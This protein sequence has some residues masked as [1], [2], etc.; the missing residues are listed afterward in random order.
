ML[1]TGLGI[2]SITMMAV[3][4]L[5]AAMTAD[6]AVTVFTGHL[7]RVNA[8]AFSPDGTQVLTGSGDKTAKLWDAFTG[9]EIRTFTGH[10]SEV[11]SVAFSPDGT[12]VLTGSTDYSAK[13]WNAASGAFVRTYSGHTDTVRS[14]AFS[15]DG[16]QVLTGSNDLSAKL[17]NMSTGALVHTFTGHLSGVYAVAFSPDGTQVLTGSGDQTAQIWNASTGVKGMA[18]GKHGAAVNSVAF[19]PDGTKVLT[20]LS[21]NTAILWNASTGALIRTFTGHTGAVNSAVFSPDGSK[22]FT[23]SLDYTAKLWNSATG[24]LLQTLAGHTY[25]VR[26]AAFSPDGAAVLTG[27]WDNTARLETLPVPKGTILIDNNHT[28]TNNTAATLGL[29]WSGGWGTGVARMRFSDDGAHWTAWEPLLATRAYT[30]P[31]GDGYKTVRVQFLDQL[32]NTSAV[33]SDYIRLDTV[34]PTGSIIINAGALSTAS[35]TVTLGLT[36][37]DGAGTGVA[38]MRF[39]DD[40]AHWTA[41]EYPKASKS[42]KLPL[43]NGYH[44]VRV[45]Y[46]DAAGNYSATYSDYIKLAMP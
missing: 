11:N 8:A 14:V 5:L 1:Q 3:A 18:F 42:Y 4:L 26:S 45:Q 12:R 21:D 43:P 6:A 17:W 9:A 13:L 28:A 46:L 30:L 24:A 20:G 35:Q 10:S 37:T 15:P 31:A 39:S 27:S 25:Y 29:T 33:F 32:N 2:R 44:T 34:A 23:G 7:S 16:T 22:V 40:G 38:R 36:Y 19:S 41:W